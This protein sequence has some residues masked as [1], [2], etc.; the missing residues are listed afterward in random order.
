MQRALA[1]EQAAHL[2]TARR[3]ASLEY[4]VANLEAG[5]SALLNRVRAIE[6]S[7]A[8]RLTGPMRNLADRFPRG[9]RVAKRVVELL[10]ASTTLRLLGRLSERKQRLERRRSLQFMPEAT[11]PTLI[12]GTVLPQDIALPDPA[13]PL[14]TVI[15]PTFGKVDYTVRCLASIAAN[16][17]QVP[18]EVIVMDDA[19]HDLGVESLARVKNL[20]LIVSDSEQGL[21][22]KL[23]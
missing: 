14:V 1:A 9:V 10:R 19:S 8:W 4:T 5:N 20:R 18:I 16:P 3:A 7:T 2:L 12:A 21:R 22:R 15:V 23:Q 13:M 6:Q 11:R 17:P